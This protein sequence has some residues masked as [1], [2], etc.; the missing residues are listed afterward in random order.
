MPLNSLIKTATAVVIA[1]VALL[2]HMAAH[3]NCYSVYKGDARIYH[4][5]TP[6]V[7]TSLPYSETVP[8]RFGA[9][10]TMIVTS[11][12]FDCPRDDEQQGG[13]VLGGS[14]Q[15]AGDVARD[16]ALSRLAERHRGYS[17]DDGA[18]SGSTA[19]SSGGTASTRGPILTGPRGGQYYLNSSGNKS[20]VSSGRGGGGRR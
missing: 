2:A 5:Q 3:A 19:G 14:W 12:S 8:A 7:D 18:N 11:G 6:P 17:D 20:Y 9:G 10:A 15:G 16:R 1:G 4:A 13:E